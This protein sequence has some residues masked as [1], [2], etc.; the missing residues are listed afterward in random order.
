MS[1]P[2]VPTRPGTARDDFI[3]RLIEYEQDYCRYMHAGI[4]QWQRET[5]M[6]RK[7]EGDSVGGMRG[8]R[9]LDQWTGPGERMNCESY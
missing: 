2:K 4:I 5:M 9:E 3:A 8:G 6:L 1:A 7:T